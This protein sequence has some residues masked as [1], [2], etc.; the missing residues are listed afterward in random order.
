MLHPLFLNREGMALLTDFY[1]LTM[2][3]AYHANGRNDPAVFELSF[4]RLPLNRSYL[5]A[6]GLEQALYYITAIRFS[7]EDIDYFRGLKAFQNVQPDFFEALRSI[8]FQWRCLGRTGRHA[9]L[10][11]RAAAAGPGSVDRRTDP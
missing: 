5:V 3:A 10:P 1:Q 11:G 7:E 2:A 4:R 6:A 8:S 9:R